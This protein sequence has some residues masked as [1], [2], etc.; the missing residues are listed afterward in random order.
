M[1]TFEKL[2]QIA[3]K[4]INNNILLVKGSGAGHGVGLSQWGAKDMAERGASFRR[5]LR[6]FYRGVEI[7]TFRDS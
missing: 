7:T 4:I 1:M 5:I 3:P 2:P 6:H